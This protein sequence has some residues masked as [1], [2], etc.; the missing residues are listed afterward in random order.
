MS[1]STVRAL[2]ITEFYDLIKPL[3]RPTRTF[4]CSFF[5]LENWLAGESENI[6]HGVDLIPEFQ[7]GHVWSHSQRT[8]YMENVLRRVCDDSTL[9]IRFNCPSWREAPHSDSDLV[10]QMVC[11]DGLQRLTAIRDFIAGKLEVFGLTF[12][13]LPKRI[14][15][16]ELTIVIKMYDFQYEDELY[17]FYLDINEG[18][19]PHTETELDRVRNL[20]DEKRR[21][22]IARQLEALS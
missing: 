22:R 8:R 17:D 16:R 12:D 7:R 4:N 2:S 19:T 13:R 9:T 18:G 21:Q 5:Y 1:Q 10:D 6:P 11:L 14:L 3:E 20:R 15:L